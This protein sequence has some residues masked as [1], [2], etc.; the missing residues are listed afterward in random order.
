MGWDIDDTILDLF[1]P[2]CFWLSTLYDAD[3]SYESIKKRALSPSFDSKK[4][5]FSQMIPGTTSEEISAFYGDFGT[6]IY[7]E[8]QFF[9]AALSIIK[10][11]LEDGMKV[12]FITARAEEWYDTT[13]QA[14]DSVGLQAAELYH[15]PHKIDLAKKLGVEVFFEDNYNNYVNLR[16]A[17]IDTILVNHPSNFKASANRSG[18][19]LV[20]FNPLY[21]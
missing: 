14:L 12:V 9:P 10:K 5:F 21:L 4:D 18:I 17:G 19:K 20:H 6:E 1:T 2:S 3:L 11:Q 13:R 8:S 15:D 16:K 7:S